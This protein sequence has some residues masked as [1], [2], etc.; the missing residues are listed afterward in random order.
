[1]TKREREQLL[2]LATRRK[3]SRIFLKTRINLND[4]YYCLKVAIQAPSGANKQPWRFL[5]I[6]EPAE[7]DKIRSACE[8]Q[9]KR[10]HEKVKRNLKRWFTAKGIDYK[11]PFL[12]EAPFLLAVFSD[13]RMPYATES[14]WLS[15]GYLLLALEEKSISSLTYTPSYAQ[16][17]K[18]IFE[19]P[20]EYKLEAILPIGLS[21]DR[22]PKEKRRPLKHSL[23]CNSWGAH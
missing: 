2:E 7:K 1:L 15:I 14:T 23:Y 4:V 17:V 21:N 19:A 8:Q 11:K 9:E 3:T 5:L 12:S 13:Q 16:E 22:K 18:K 20:K 6:D 10:F